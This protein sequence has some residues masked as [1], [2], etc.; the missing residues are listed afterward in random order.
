MPFVDH[1]SPRPP[2]NTPHLGHWIISGWPSIQDAELSNRTQPI[3]KH[4]KLN[5]Q[6]WSFP[7]PVST[8]E[9]VQQEDFWEVG[10][11]QYGF[12]LL[13]VARQAQR[14]GRL[15]SRA[16]GFDDRGYPLQVTSDNTTVI[17]YVAPEFYRFRETVESY[18]NIMN[19]NPDHRA[20]YDFGMRMLQSAQLRDQFWIQVDVVTDAVTGILNSMSNPDNINT[21]EHRRQMLEEQFNFLQC[22]REAHQTMIIRMLEAEGV[23]E[24]IYTERRRDL[25]NWN[26]GTRIFVKEFIKGLQSHGNLGDTT[27]DQDIL[28][29]EAICI[30]ICRM[31]L[32]SPDGNGTT[33]QVELAEVAALQKAQTEFNC[34]DFAGCI[35]ACAQLVQLD[36]SSLFADACAHLLAGK[37][38]SRP[39]ADRVSAIE[40]ANKIFSD[41]ILEAANKSR[42][43]RA[44][45]AWRLSPE[46]TSTLLTLSREADTLH[47]AIVLARGMQ[48]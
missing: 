24:A 7:I 38:T 4:P 22:A 1:A 46:W 23:N 43:I 26:R 44:P 6:Q 21:I 34:A 25:I 45:P 8:Y 11:R 29:R 10:I 3:L 5:E 39:D 32:C 16:G 33:D 15:I 28:H 47:T 42:R 12:Q 30:E 48:S 17:P 2:F 20:A 36:A 9:D 27:A 18:K 41:L 37:V 35:A 31:M 13:H 14:G 19:M 40:R